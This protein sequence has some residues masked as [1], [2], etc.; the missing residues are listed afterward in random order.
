[1]PTGWDALATF[2]CVFLEG[3]SGGQALILSG[4][5]SWQWILVEFSQWKPIPSLFEAADGKA[6]A[7]CPWYLVS[8]A[9]VY[10]LGFIANRRFFQA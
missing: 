8:Q 4:R 3:Y 6:S 2:S 7:V 10:E 1:L 9:G 5:V